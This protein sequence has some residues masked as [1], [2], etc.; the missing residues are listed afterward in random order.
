MTHEFFDIISR[1]EFE[2]RLCSFPRLDAVA[3]P[4]SE[5]CGRVPAAPFTAPENLPLTDRSCMDGFALSA[6]DVFGAGETNPA[7]L[8]NVLDIRVDQPPAAPLAPGE[9]ARIP[10]GGSLPE[11]ADAVVMVEHTHSMDAPEEGPGTIEIRKSVAPGE[12]VMLR[13]EDAEAGKTALPEGRRLRAVDVGLVAALG[14]DSLE[15]VRVPRVGILSTGDELQEITAPPRPG[16]V[17]D[18]NGYTL[19]CLASEVG[20]EPIHLGIVRDD[21]AALTAAL[22]MAV[23]RYDAVFLSG[24]SSVGMRDLTVRAIK[25]Q[26]D[27]EVLAHGV[28][29]SPGKPLIL[30]RVGGT[31]VLGLPGQVTSVQVVM[32]V[33]V[34]PFLRHLAGEAS[35]FDMAARTRRAVVARNTA[36]R[37][38]REDFV[39][40]R[41][42]DTGA[43]LPLAHPLP[44]KSGLLSTMLAADALLRIPADVEGV[45]EGAEAEILPL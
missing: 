26:P 5:A 12:N 1:A 7:Y 27:A 28:A 10:T 38:G 19:C 43:G 25:A 2:A 24:G 45:Y 3:I 40:V 35:A 44:G 15:V 42:E 41:L 14:V 21:L 4:L 20:A 23:E 11:G 17:R 39:R 18:V 29:I 22:E 8:E 32:H 30:A 13:G 34:L 37:Q 36:S 31:P 16:K 6:R 33:L 9:C